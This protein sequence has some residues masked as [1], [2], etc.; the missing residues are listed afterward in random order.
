MDAQK[1][2]HVFSKPEIS[3]QQKF[4]GVLPSQ[5]K[6][7]HTHAHNSIPERK[8]A[9]VH[10]KIHREKIKS[11]QNSSV[12]IYVRTVIC[13][14]QIYI[15]YH[16]DGY[17]VLHK[18]KRKKGG[19]TAAGHGHLWKRTRARCRDRK[20]VKY[21]VWWGGKTWNVEFGFV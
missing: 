14:Y 16:G 12:Y 15:F 10:V 8:Q 5:G 7:K 3:W 1:L 19:D 11:V 20:A 6:K 18:K 2:C 9:N 17:I 4:L 13:R 21:R